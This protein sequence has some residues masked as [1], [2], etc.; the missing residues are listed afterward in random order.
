M[1]KLPY[2][3]LHC[4]KLLNPLV[5]LKFYPNLNSHLTTP[6]Y[7][8]RN[9]TSMRVKSHVCLLSWKDTLTLSDAHDYHTTTQFAHLEIPK[10]PFMV[11]YLG[12]DF[13]YRRILKRVQYSFL[14]VMY[15]LSSSV[16]YNILKSYKFIYQTLY[17]LQPY[18]HFKQD[19]FLLSLKSYKTIR[20]QT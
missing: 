19:F 16:T 15:I 9:V 1:I 11:N 8:L 6:N 13:I 3:W 10:Y 7:T 2:R 14:I 5:Y 12:P 18:S 4:S 17:V 20:V